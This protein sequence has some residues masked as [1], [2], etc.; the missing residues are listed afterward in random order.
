MSQY[1]SFPDISKLAQPRK[2]WDQVRRIRGEGSPKSQLTELDGQR[3]SAAITGVFARH[4]SEAGLP[5]DASAADDEVLASLLTDF[6]PISADEFRK[7]V[8]DK[9]KIGKTLDHLGICGEHF[10]FGGV[11]AAEFRATLLS[12]L[13]H[14]RIVPLPMRTSVFVPLLMDNR[15]EAN[16]VKRNWRT[17]ITNIGTIESI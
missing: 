11:L 10:V 5:H 16:R 13:I 7:A 14:S 4:F 9:I 15:L 12:V 1:V 8:H 3:V 17:A 6:T 2:F